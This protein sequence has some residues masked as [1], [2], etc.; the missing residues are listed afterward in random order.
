MPSPPIFNLSSHVWNIIS[1][2]RRCTANKTQR[3]AC[4]PANWAG[5]AS[6]CQEMG[7]V[8][9]TNSFRPS[10]Q[11]PRLKFADGGPNNTEAQLLEMLERA[12]M[13]H[14]ENKGTKLRKMHF[15]FGNRS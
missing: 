12:V 2:C 6:A 9:P 8:H 1:A 15:S 5:T 7:V 13:L 11:T 4:L 14:N 10:V 3:K